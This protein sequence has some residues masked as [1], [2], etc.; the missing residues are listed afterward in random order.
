MAWCTE[1]NCWYKA[2]PYVTVGRLLLRFPWSPCYYA[3]LPSYNEWVDFTNCHIHQVSTV[4]ISLLTRLYRLSAREG[5]FSGCLAG[6]RCKHLYL[7]TCILLATCTWMS[8]ALVEVS[9]RAFW[10][11][12]WQ[13]AS[14]K[15]HLLRQ[16]SPP[17]LNTRCSGISSLNLGE[18]RFL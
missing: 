12:P 1:T 13:T 3:W 8:R 16:N 18:V 15:Q 2:R 17:K 10:H 4:E 6:L 14:R 7:Y 5:V 11:I 9:T